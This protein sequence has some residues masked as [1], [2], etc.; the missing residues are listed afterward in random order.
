MLAFV[1]TCCC[2]CILYRPTAAV[3]HSPH[4]D[5]AEVDPRLMKWLTTWH[6]LLTNVSLRW[7]I[8]NVEL[9]KNRHIL[10]HHIPSGQVWNRWAPQDLR[11]GM[12]KVEAPRCYYVDADL[13]KRYLLYEMTHIL[14][15]FTGFWR[16]ETRYGY[17]L[18]KAC[19]HAYFPLALV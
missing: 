7:R 5:V 16:C 2:T 1:C 14:S 8:W 4:R 18:E 3:C 10:W 13:H 15:L 17:I 11:Y 12:T 9:L 19:M 6:H